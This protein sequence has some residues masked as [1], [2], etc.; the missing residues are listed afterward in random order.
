MEDVIP[1]MKRLRARVPTLRC[2]T[3]KSPVHLIEEN[4]PILSLVG[5]ISQLERLVL[6]DWEWGDPSSSAP[7]F[8]HLKP[9]KALKVRPPT[10]LSPIP[11]IISVY[12]AC[13]RH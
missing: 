5:K 8:Q 2:L 7:T 12:F 9:L 10:H 13:R 11:P 1:L 3:I 6:K 4:P